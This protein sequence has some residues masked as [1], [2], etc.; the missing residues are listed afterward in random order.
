VIENFTTTI[1]RGDKIG[2]CGLNGSGKTTLLQLLLG[3]LEP[4]A[5]RVTHG[6]RLEVAY[7]DQHRAQLDENL[8]VAENVFP[9]GETVTLNGRA[10]HILS[11]LQDFLFTAETARAP[12]RKLSGGERA[13]LL[14]ARLF[15]QP[16]NLLVLD[17]PTNDLDIETVELLE[18]RLLE[19]SGTMLLVSH[20]RA[21][22]ENVATSTLALEADGEVREYTM[23]PEEWVKDFERR[24]A[25][26]GKKISGARE[27]SKNTKERKPQAR[28]LLNKER[29]ALRSLPGEIELLEKEHAELAER[30]STPDYYQNVENDPAADAR[31]LEDLEKRTLESYE[32]WEEL[33]EWV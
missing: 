20:D 19:F 2:I 18:D 17:E 28:K 4:V 23:G 32:R 22:L 21:F 15:L 14:L 12:I 16:A 27:T 30:M 24:N 9:G 3:K 29:E 33:S 31:R 13:R 11:Y 10:R 8:S 1:W 7:F 6:T 26:S 5:G 25:T